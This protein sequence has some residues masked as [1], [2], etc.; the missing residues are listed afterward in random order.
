[1]LYYKG[2]PGLDP[3]GC[4]LDGARPAKRPARKA[5][6]WF[7]KG[8]QTVSGSERRRGEG[9]RSVFN[10]SRRSRVMRR[11]GHTQDLPEILQSVQDMPRLVNWPYV[12]WLLYTSF[13]FPI[14]SSMGI[15]IGARAN[16]FGQ[17]RPKS[18][19]A[20]GASLPRPV[21]RGTWASSDRRSPSRKRSPPR[22]SV[23][24]GHYAPSRNSSPLL[25]DQS[26]LSSIL[27]VTDVTR[28]SQ[29]IQRD[30]AG[31]GYEEYVRYRNF[32]NE[33][34]LDSAESRRMFNFVEPK[35]KFNCANWNY[36]V[37]KFDGIQQRRNTQRCLIF[38]KKIKW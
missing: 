24:F 34:G 1:M 38:Q 7:Y 17:S 22:V 36:R 11:A 9:A 3:V 37:L 2:T 30:H 16:L 26:R 12:L 28:I 19:A 21:F 20:P 4:A 33:R 5:R 31:E 23:S 18:P 13:P 27:P 10:C 8:T 15:S 35:W 14:R 6:Y 32:L 29:P 25:S